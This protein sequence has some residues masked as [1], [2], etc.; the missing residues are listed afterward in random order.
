MNPVARVLAINAETLERKRAHDAERLDAL[1]RD[2]SH[3]PLV[4][5]AARVTASPREFTLSVSNVPGPRE[6]LYVLGRR[7]GALYSVAEIAPGHAVR[8][9]ALTASGVLSFGIC[10]DPEVVQ[11][12]DRLAAGIVDSVD[13]LVARTAG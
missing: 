4:R 8:V 3:V 2:I 5:G 13:A 7:L 12:L 9:A 6:P 1:L 11:N 10:A